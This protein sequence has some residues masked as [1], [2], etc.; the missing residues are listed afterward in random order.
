LG[1]WSGLG[2]VCFTIIGDSKE[3]PAAVVVGLGKEGGGRVRSYGVGCFRYMTCGL[4]TGGE[5]SLVEI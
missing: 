3:L 2:G 1:L 5:G 4:F